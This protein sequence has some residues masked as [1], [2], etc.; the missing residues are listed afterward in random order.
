MSVSRGDAF[1]YAQLQKVKDQSLSFSANYSFRSKFDLS[2]SAS[3]YQFLAN[4]GK[5]SSQSFYL[6]SNYHFNLKHHLKLI[7][8][9]GAFADHSILNPQNGFD[10]RKAAQYQLSY[11][12]K[13]SAFKYFIAGVSSAANNANSNASLETNRIYAFSKLVWEF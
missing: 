10:T 13:P 8:S 5:T 1:D 3:N 6:S 9:Y 7:G 11:Q 4:A 12:Y 2:F